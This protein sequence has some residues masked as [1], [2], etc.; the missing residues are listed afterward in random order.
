MASSMSILSE[1]KNGL[2]MFIDELIDQFPSEADLVII[3]IFLNDQVPIVD[4]IN[5]VI[6]NLLPFK[7]QIKN[8]DEK[9]LIDS[10]ILFEKLSKSKVNYFKKLWRS[11]SLDDDDRII[12]WKWIDSFI[13]LASKYQAILKQ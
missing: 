9:V 8:R 13:Y 4:V 11:N 3:R 6:V 1:F 10:D 2:I 12:I 5:H 7:N